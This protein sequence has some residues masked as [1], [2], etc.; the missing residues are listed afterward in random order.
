MDV[1]KKVLLAII[2]YSLFPNAPLSCIASTSYINQSK[3]T[4]QK[5][6]THLKRNQNSSNEVG[7]II[8]DGKEYVI[9]GES[10]ESISKRVPSKKLV[11]L[12]KWPEFPDGTEGLISYLQSNVIYPL[13][14]IKEK[15]EGRVIVLFTFEP[16]GT[17]KNIQ[18]ETPV[19]PLLDEEAVRVVKSMPKWIPALTTEGKTARVKYSIPIVFKL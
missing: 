10:K 2:A 3:V 7:V 9:V 15:I 18:V 6:K 19:S 17:L 1:K 5:V 4:S 8:K 11:K 14:A 13:D 16:D 12:A